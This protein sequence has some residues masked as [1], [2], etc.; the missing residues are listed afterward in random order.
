MKKSEEQGPINLQHYTI[1]LLLARRCSRAAMHILASDHVDDFIIDTSASEVGDHDVCHLFRKLVHV[2][3]TY[4][5]AGYCGVE[6]A[7]GVE[8]R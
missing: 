2:G 4:T 5:L 7:F 3:S 1:Y 8:S 6:Q